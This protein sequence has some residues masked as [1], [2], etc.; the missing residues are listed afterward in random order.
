VKSPRVR[1]ALVGLLLVTNSSCG[2]ESARPAALCAAATAQPGELYVQ[3]FEGPCLD[4]FNLR[5]KSVEI[6]SVDPLFGEREARWK[7]ANAKLTAAQTREDGPYYSSWLDL[8]AVTPARPVCVD[9]W[10]RWMG[11]GEGLVFGVRR[12]GADQVDLG[13]ENVIMGPAGFVDPEWGEVTEIGGDNGH[14]VHL[15]KTIQVPED[16]EYLQ[17]FANID[18]RFRGDSEEEDFAT[19]EARFD[20]VRISKEACEAQG[21]PSVCQP[22]DVARGLR[23]EY[24]DNKEFTNPKLT[25]VDGPIAFDWGLRTPYPLIGVETYAVRWTGFVVPRFTEAYRFFT[26][27]DDGAKLTVNGQVLVNNLSGQNSGVTNT[28]LQAGQAYP[29]T[30]E[31]FDNT[32]LAQ[33]TLEWQSATGGGQQVKEFIPQDRLQPPTGTS[34]TSSQTLIGHW[35]LDDMSGVTAADATCKANHGTL[36]SFPSAPSW[37]TGTEGGA[38]TFDG[39]T[40]WVRVPDSEALDSVGATD[41]ITVSAWVKRTAAQ[42]M[43]VAYAMV[44]MRQSSAVLTREQW[45]LGFHN[46]KLAWLVNSDGPGTIEC[47]APDVAPLNQWMHITGTYNG[48]VATLYRDGAPICSFAPT[49]VGLSGETTPVVIGAGANAADETMNEFFAGQIDDVIIYDRALSSA[50]VVSTQE[51]GVCTPAAGPPNI[52]VPGEILAEEDGFTG[53][54]VVSYTVSA[55][56][57][58]SGASLVPSC[59]P[60]SGSIFLLGTTVVTCT[61]QGM[62]PVGQAAFKVR[63]A[64]RNRGNRVALLVVGDPV[65]GSPENA[66]KGRLVAAG[67]EVVV[68]TGSAVSTSDA[69]NKALIV[70]TESAGNGQV[71]TKFNATRVPV[72]AMN[73]GL[74]RDMTL[75][76]DT[77]QDDKGLAQNQADLEIVA[78]EHALAAGFRGRVTVTTKP[79]ELFWGRPAATAIKV[80]TL[81]GSPDQAAIYAYTTGSLLAPVAG[82]T[83]LEAPAR[84]V[85]FFTGNEAAVFLSPQGISLLDMAIR[86]ATQ[87]EALVVVGSGV[88]ATHKEGDD[89][90]Q[91][92][93]IDLGYGVVVKTG[94]QVQ[95]AHADSAEL[96]L[97]TDSITAGDVANRLTDT[98][99]P[100]L[101]LKAELWASLKMVGTGTSEYG[102]VNG[103]Q[104]Q[105]VTPSHALAAGLTGTIA[106]ANST[107][108]IKWGKP[109][110]TAAKVATI[111]NQSTN[112]TIFGYPTGTAMVGLSAPGRRV[113][114]FASADLPQK[115]TTD[116]W[117]L[118]DAAVRWGAER[119]PTLAGIYALQA[120]HSSKCVEVSGGSLSDS[121]PL[122]QMDCTGLARQRWILRDLSGG[123]YEVSSA[124]SNKCA[125]VSG[126]ST[127]TGAAIIQLGCSGSASQTWKLTDMGGGL[128]QLQPT[129]SNKCMDVDGNSTANGTAIQQWTCNNGNNQRFRLQP[130]GFCLG[131]TDAELCAAGGKNC[132]GLNA[133]DRCGSVRPITSCGTCTAPQTCGGAGTANV[134]GCM[135][136]SAATFCSRL[137]KNCGSVTAPDN[138]NV[139]RTYNCG[140]CSGF[141]VCG[142]G[143]T[144]NVCGCTPETL[145]QFCSRLGKNCGMVTGTDNCGFPRTA[146]S[147]GTCTSPQTCGGGG[148]ANVCGCAAET[149]AQFCTR[150]GKNCGSVTAND[151]CGNSRT[152]S[153]CGTCTSPQVCGGNGTANVCAA[154]ACTFSITANSYDGPSWWGSI[155]FRNNGPSTSSHYKLEFDVPTGVHCTNDAV[156][157]GSTLS[158]LTGSGSSAKTTSNHCIFTW[159]N[160]PALAANATKPI[161]YSTDSNSSSFTAASAVTVS[162]STC[163]VCTPETNSAFCSRLGKNCGSVTAADNCGTNRTVS[164]CGTCTSPATC[165]GSGTANVCGVGGNACTFTVVQNRYDGPNWW[166]NIDFKNDGPNNASN[167]R[168]VFTLPS[169]VHCDYADDGWSYS[170]SGTT[171]T[172]QKVGTTFTAGAGPVTVN[173][174]TDSNSSSLKNFSNLVV[175]DTVCTGAKLSMLTVYDTTYSNAVNWAGKTNF[176]IGSSGAH[177]WPDYSSTYVDT[178]DS[179]ISGNLIGKVWVQTQSAS[180][181]YNPSSA[182]LAQGRITLGSQANVYLVVDDRVAS[183]T[184]SGAGWTDTTYNAVIKEAGTTNRTFSVWK[185]ANQTGGVDLP[186]QNYNGAFNYFV[187][188]E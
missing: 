177:P 79:T 99:T 162:D 132:G 104:V 52:V 82:Q 75:T 165:G 47:D 32:G 56:D 137:G 54:A 173:I 112:V 91:A 55:Y 94:A 136:E 30:L 184:W 70:V 174:S 63:V 28:V 87:S 48:E 110:A 107:G 71:G 43:G 1:T 21:F 122:V 138:C 16:T 10:T 131:E 22:V 161:N 6:D 8:V 44:A 106:V 126:G 92:R 142:G 139:S 143:G 84:R 67:Y 123:N 153:S 80:A 111:V 113:G 160:G 97:V 83:T 188:V 27:S 36:R 168:V 69:N 171:C 141:D 60:A 134:C 170:Q 166:G 86:W 7:P 100:L 85:G 15:K 23:G 33:I 51:G 109:A 147:C 120:V 187:V 175:S 119:E 152:V 76:G 89:K 73:L 9:L 181:N 25:R 78:P 88:P 172:Y 74:M 40:N 149:N 121:A 101:G 116:G 135:S 114:W 5:R 46:N 18:W 39:A 127:T 37:S 14:W 128:Y 24:F 64:P 103:T 167:L 158:P 105:I 115:L 65:L 66:I 155:T 118:F 144:A 133:T 90:L 180:K 176:Q 11:L 34:C 145:P 148:M 49:T 50:E 163:M 19:K 96:V 151:N 129:H 140:A 182:P 42:P 61:A 98:K 4:W 13:K 156:P 108:A 146:P 157:P 35:K 179:G 125:D 102:S 150:L 20:G 93:L 17:V 62:G 164:S 169:G 154:A 3:D 2:R 53:Q 117:K 72:I 185:K 38:L 159:P 95:A 77:Y 183:S 59:M 26:T 41:Q 178:V 124:N 58:P 68:K 29:V 130:A 12:F 31:W 81:A 57:D 45:A 186:I